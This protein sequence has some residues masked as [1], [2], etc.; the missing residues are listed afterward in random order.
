MKIHYLEDPRTRTTT[1]KRHIYKWD[2]DL[3]SCFTQDTKLV[4]CKHCLFQIEKKFQEFN[5]LYSSAMELA[6]TAKGGLP[7][8]EDQKRFLKIGVLC[9]IQASREDLPILND[10]FKELT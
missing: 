1:C 10:L 6:R 2:Y 7:L 4:T 3:G 9:G 5:K 8:S